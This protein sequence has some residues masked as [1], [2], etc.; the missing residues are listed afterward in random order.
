MHRASSL[1]NTWQFSRKPSWTLD[2]EICVWIDHKQ[3]NSLIFFFFPV[4]RLICHI[5]Q[6]ARCSLG[7]RNSFITST[8]K[9]CAWYWNMLIVLIHEFHTLTRGTVIIKNTF[10]SPVA[11]DDR[12][13][14]GLSCI[15]L[16][17]TKWDLPFPY[18]QHHTKSM[19]SQFST[20]EI[21]FTVDESICIKIKWKIMSVV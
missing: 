19:F 1:V 15:L 10:Q 2:D 20:S 9:H 7:K 12:S 8:R 13:G 14:N 16:K 18:H 3:E 4:I 17:P 6:N 21:D 11:W 5:R